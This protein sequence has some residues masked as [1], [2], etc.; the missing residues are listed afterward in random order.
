MKNKAKINY[1]VDII[2]GAGFILS[3]VSGLILFFT[4]RGGFMGGRNLMV[5]QDVLF[6]SKY[7]WKD[8][9]TW[10]SMAMALG[11]LGHLILHWKWFVCMTK[12]LFKIK[13]KDRI[14]LSDTG[15]VI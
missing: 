12:S 2:I 8:I 3:L 14:A 15:G 7:M 1:V 13:T 9:H 11:V 6:F 4:P 5:M 10:S